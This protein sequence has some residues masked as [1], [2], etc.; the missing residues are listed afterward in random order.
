MNKYNDILIGPH[1]LAFDITNCCNLRCLHCFN[2]SGEN[3]VIKSE[4]SDSEVISLMKDIRK[5]NLYSICFCGGETLLRS[6]LIKESIKV[7]K[8]DNGSIK[9][10]LVT[11][12]ILATKEVID[13]LV[14]AGLDGIQFSIDGLK[15]SHER[16]RNKKG[17]FNNV[18]DA[19]DYCINN[20][21]LNISVAFTPTVFNIYEFIS[22]Y[23]IL[24]H[25]FKGR[26]DNSVLN[27]RSQ[28]LMLLG[29]AKSNKNICPSNHQYRKL[30]NYIRLFQK[31]VSE[32]HISI[33]WGDPIDHLIR[34]RDSNRFVNDQLNIH[35]NGDIIISAY[36]PL[37]IGNIRKYSI[38][39]YWNKGNL[40]SIW[41]TKIVQYL[42]SKIKC[43][44]DMELITNS[45]A[46]INT[47]D[48]IYL[49]AIED[50]LN[51]LD[52][53]KDIVNILQ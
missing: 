53:I 45:I 49:D 21:K 41:S 15:N 35:A 52:L 20:T 9:C 37:V 19:L 34:S 40:S 38:N 31:T 32:S 3:D 25:K 23:E 8:S 24:K 1:Q 2:S 16:M 27:L 10:S 28:P 36:L 48:C 51:D 14:D 13:D 11:N 43:I 29:R 47:D 18:M 50:D 5:L 4:L 12:G 7:L 26:T 30:I 22:L 33:E 42:A 17:I 39:E 44:D 46:E 6:K